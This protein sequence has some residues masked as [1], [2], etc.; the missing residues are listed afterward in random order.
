MMD[1]TAILIALLL[2]GVALGL[3][4]MATEDRD[5]RRAMQAQDDRIAQ[6]FNSPRPAPRPTVEDDCHRPDVQVFVT[7]NGDFVSQEIEA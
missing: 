7:A 5:D 6:E 1:P 4:H 3:V 2:T